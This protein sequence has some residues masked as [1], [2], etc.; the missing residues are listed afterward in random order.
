MVSHKKRE[1]VCLPVINYFLGFLVTLEAALFTEDVTC[2]I[3]ASQQINPQASSHPQ[4]SST[5]TTARAIQALNQKSNPKQTWPT[6][7]PHRVVV[8]LQQK[9]FAPIGLLQSNKEFLAPNES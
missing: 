8:L 1:F 4:G 9:M 6:K 5:I 2:F 3:G 7:N